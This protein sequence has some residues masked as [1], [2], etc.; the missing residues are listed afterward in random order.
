MSK[1]FRTKAN[2][3]F[4]DDAEPLRSPIRLPQRRPTEDTTDSKAGDGNTGDGPVTIQAVTASF[5]AATGVLSV[6][7]DA[8][9]NTLTISR[10]AAGNILVN[11][12]AVQ[13]LGGTPSVANT[14]MIQ[15]FGLSGN[16]RIVLDES[17]GALPRATL[18]GGAGNDSIT[19]GSGNDMLFGQGDNDILSGKGGTDMLFGGAGNDTLTG[20]DGDDLVFGES[21]DDRMIWNAGDDTDLFE[22]GAGIDTAEVNGGNGAEN[23]TVTANGARVR[24]D[25]VD[26]APFALDIGTTENLVVN[27]NGG[28]DFFSATGNLAALIKITV[29]GGAGNDTILGSNGIDLLLGGDGNDRLVG[30]AGNDR[31][32]GGDGKDVAE[33]GD[34]NDRLS[35]GAG[36]DKLKGQGNK[37][38]LKGG[39]G[40]RDVCAGGPGKDRATKSCERV[41]SA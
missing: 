9:D 27:M 6:F 41:R 28:D 37:D 8:A 15:V 17:N 32:L 29:D 14:S 1:L 39:P 5:S 7:G 33:G 23:F 10:N 24:F 36:N 13:I 19:G 2:G 12:G 4:T 34:G 20:G 30:E 16:D 31:L 21:G 22:G 40:K 25:R 38:R 11:G 26:P 18:F 3:I 35:G